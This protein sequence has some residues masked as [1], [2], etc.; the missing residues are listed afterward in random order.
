MSSLV[1]THF[2]AQVVDMVQWHSTQTDVIPKG[3]AEAA[4][5]MLEYGE[6]RTREIVDVPVITRVVSTEPSH[7]LPGANLNLSSHHDVEAFVGIHSNSMCGWCFKWQPRIVWRDSQVRLCALAR[8]C[9][10]GVGTVPGSVW[11]FIDKF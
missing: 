7:I 2:D 10:H 4:L 6:I 11:G 1:P 3:G 8:G 9:G 5:M